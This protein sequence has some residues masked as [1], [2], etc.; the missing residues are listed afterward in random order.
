MNDGSG[1]PYD[2]EV[3]VTEKY[4]TYRDLGLNQDITSDY[5]FTEEYI[6]SSSP[7]LG[8]FVVVTRNGGV[9]G[10]PNNTYMRTRYFW[11]LDPGGLP[12]VVLLNQN[13]YR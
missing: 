12:I 5:T 11:D 4:N 9:T 13:F 2:W 6:D 3:Q 8:V 1:L 10:P 7:E